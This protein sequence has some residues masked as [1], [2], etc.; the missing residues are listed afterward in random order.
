VVMALRTRPQHFPVHC[1]I[2]TQQIMRT[3]MMVARYTG[4]EVQANKAIVGRNAFAHESGIHQHGVLKHANTYEIITPESVGASSDL[5]LGKHSGKAAYKARLIE[6]GY[7]DVAQDEAALK[8]LV[9]GAKAVADQKKSVSDQDLEMLLGEALYVGHEDTWELLSLNVQTDTKNNGNN[10]TAT[11][12]VKL[13]DVNN[14]EECMEAAIGVGPVDA[15]FKAISRMVKRPATLTHYNISKVHGGTETPGNDALA[16][17]VLHIQ[18]RGGDEA[19]AMPDDFPGHQGAVYRP[20]DLS[21]HMPRKS[22]PGATLTYNGNGTSTDVI[23]ASAKAYLDALNRM[24]DAQDKR[25]RA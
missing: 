22:K 11:A 15:T 1:T 18:E 12:T 7:D 17:V 20:N 23:V 21:D 13:K 16:S 5:V 19:P 2:N 10:V 4:I 6:M 24:I 14:G 25:Q 9:D 3:S 8:R